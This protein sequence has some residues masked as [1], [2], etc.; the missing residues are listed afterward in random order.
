MELLL[1]KCYLLVHNFIIRQVLPV[2]QVEKDGAPGVVPDHNLP[3]HFDFGV[4]VQVEESDD[5]GGPL[6]ADDGAEHVERDG[7]QPIFL[8]ECH[9]ESE[10]N[11]YHDVNILEHCIQRICIKNVMRET[12]KK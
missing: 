10:T 4:V 3:I 1:H 7:T 2:N 5:E 6:K 12:Y 8:Q 11:E 9:Q